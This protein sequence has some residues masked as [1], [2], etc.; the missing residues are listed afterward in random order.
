[1][2]NEL[3]TS[4]TTEAKNLLTH[5]LA[6]K[7]ADLKNL[8]TTGGVYLVFDKSGSVIYVGKAVNLRRR[9]LEDHRGGDEK[10]STSTLRRSVSKK[11]DIVPGRPTRDWIRENCQFSYI[12]IENHDLRDLVETLAIAYFRKS[13]E[14]L[15]NFHRD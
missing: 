7:L 6:V 14:E 2:D 10:M 12:E 3:L 5:L 13:G 4:L 15:L 8:P 9:I 1:M 11:Y